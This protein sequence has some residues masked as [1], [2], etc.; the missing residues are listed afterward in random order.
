MNKSNG[1]CALVIGGSGLIGKILIQNLLE[2]NKYE[3]VRVLVRSNIDIKHPKLEVVI[4]NFDNPNS[5]LV[6]GDDVYCCLGTTMKKA[7]NKENFYKVDY[8]YPVQIATT[9]LANG[10]KRFAIV[11]AMGANSKSLFYYNRV[12]GQVEETLKSLNFESLFIFRPSLLLGER[13][14]AR[15]GEKVGEKL[16]RVFKPLIPSKYKAIEASKVAYAMLAITTSNLKGTAIYE[17]DV[18]QE[19]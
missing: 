3:R 18:L 12:K 8:Q 6:V 5:A 2:S 19:F 9:A 13:Y 16:A 17:S 4:F 11:T 15:I 7:G 14:E 10:A 1:R